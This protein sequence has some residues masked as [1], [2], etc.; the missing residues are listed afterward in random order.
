MSA[1]KQRVHDLERLLIAEV[2]RVD[3]DRDAGWDA[4]SIRRD[5]ADGYHVSKG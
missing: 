4:E 5:F 1:A 2:E 3:E